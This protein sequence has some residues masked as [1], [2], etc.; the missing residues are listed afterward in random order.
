MIERQA[1]LGQVAGFQGLIHMLRADSRQPDSEETDEQSRCYF[2][3][4][5]GQ[6][7]PA[8]IMLFISVPELI[9]KEL[10]RVWHPYKWAVPQDTNGSSG[11]A[12]ASSQVPQPLLLALGL[13]P[14]KNNHLQVWGVLTLTPLCKHTDSV[15]SWKVLTSKALVGYNC[16]QEPRNL[17]S[18]FHE[19]LGA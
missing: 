10:F 6:T 19:G 12:L 2:I 11:S 17:D 15:V 14:S 8:T 1:A 5:S 7:Q 13:A 3:A 9:L 16:I 4:A 18:K